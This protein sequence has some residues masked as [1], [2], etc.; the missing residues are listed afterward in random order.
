VDY[1]TSDFSGFDWVGEQNFVGEKKV[2][3]RPCLVF[4]DKVVTVE[5]SQLE[6]IKSTIDRDFNWMGQIDE[7]GR[8]I[9][10]TQ[11]SAP[12]RRIFNIEDYKTQVTAYIDAETRLPIALVYA[13]PQGAVTRTYQFQAL[14]SPLVIPNEVRKV[15]EA[16]KARQK[17]LNVSRAPI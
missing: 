11:A 12:A 2:N 9:S 1:N 17:R 7:N 4:Q 3:G 6:M 14:P 5:P 13:S 16:S 8:S 10:G 15:L